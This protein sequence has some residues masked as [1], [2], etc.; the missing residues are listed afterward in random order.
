MR[1]PVQ[2]ELVGYHDIAGVALDPE[3]SNVL[4]VAYGKY[5]PNGRAITVQEY[6]LKEK[7]WTT[8]RKLRVGDY[9]HRLSFNGKFM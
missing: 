7:T 8:V 6:R 5:T 4:V 1:Q 2:A 9:G 3:D